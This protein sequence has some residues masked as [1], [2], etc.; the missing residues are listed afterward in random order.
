MKKNIFIGLLSVLLGFSLGNLFMKD[1]DYLNPNW[2]K[3]EKYYFIEEGIYSSLDNLKN[4]LIDVREKVIDYNN[5]KYYVYLGITKNKKLADK[6]IDIYEKK[7]I[8]VHTVE[9]F[10]DSEEFLQNVLQFDNLIKSTSEED[11]VLTIESVVLAN[12]EEIMKK[13]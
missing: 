12:Y 5:K 9:K 2:N 7:G 10:L 8:K 6:I 4:N 1:K 13:E 3:K 11:Q